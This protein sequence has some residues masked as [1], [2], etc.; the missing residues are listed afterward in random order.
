ML[1]TEIK[2]LIDQNPTRLFEEEKDYAIANNLISADESTEI[3]PAG[4]RWA[5]IYIERGH[6][7]TEEYLG[8]ETP[9]FLKE[10]IS[11]LKTHQNEFIYVE[12]KWFEIL[13]IEGIIFEEND[14]FR[15]YDTIFGLKVQKKHGDLL[16]KVIL[17]EFSADAKYSIL[18]NGNDGLWDINLPISHLNGFS[19]N[20]T[21]EEVLS[22][23]YQLLFK[24]VWELER[25]K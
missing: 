19:E 7:E 1:H 16:R 23:T 10:N 13:G 17:E 24:L 11:Y 5:D 22:L 21:I 20:M 12:S 2:K 14:V 9:S 18:F 15:T 3:L 4:K 6:K 8:E 25:N